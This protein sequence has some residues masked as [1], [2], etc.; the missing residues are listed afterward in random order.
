MKIIVLG[1]GIIGVTT[2]YFLS[3][4]G[5]EVFVIDKAKSPGLATSFANGGQL[6]YS[7]TDALA[8]PALA[9]Q[10]PKLLKG[11]EPAFD[12]KWAI[13]LFSWGL[14]F[15]R[16]C[17]KS[18]AAFN[19]ENILRL[20]MYSREM[21]HQILSLHS[22]EFNYQ[23]N[24]KLHLYS[25]EQTFKTALQYV[26]LKNHWGCQQQVLTPQ[27]CLAKEPALEHFATKIV[28]GIFSPKDES[29]DSYLFTR[30][31]TDLCV[32][33][34]SVQF[35]YESEIT[36]LEVKKGRISRVKTT[37]D[38][39]YADAFV[40]CLGA[41]SPLLCQTIGIH[42]PIYP[43]KGYS[44]TMPATATAPTINITDIDHKMIYTTLGDKLRIGG[45]LEMCGYDTP[46]NQVRLKKMIQTAQTLFPDAGDFRQLTSW[47]GLRAGTPDSAPIIGWTRYPNLYL[48]TGHTMLGWTL[49]AGSAAVV[50]DIINDSS[51]A[52]DLT[53]LT[54]KRF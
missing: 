14:R 11:Q 22:I 17:T 6:S 19:T 16:N 25:S 40:V 7:Y 49:A 35:L 21:I 28:G 43:L 3:S 34:N 36:A 30:A 46:I 33:Y 41:E 27:A 29:G 32:K 26:N 8:N 47:A 23:Q 44:L 50:A 54:L 15:L 38:S 45:V 24:G 53:G 2:A 1:A 48:N 12:M 4:A 39:Y 13:N 18:R 10:L 52:I 31:L 9:V 51:P 42:L 37:D 20:S 5:H